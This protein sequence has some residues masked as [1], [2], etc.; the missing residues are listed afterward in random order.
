[1]SMSEAMDWND[2]FKRPVM[3]QSMKDTIARLERDN[4]VLRAEN[5]RLRE[6]LTSVLSAFSSDYTVHVLNEMFSD[7]H[8]GVL[9]AARAALE[10]K[11]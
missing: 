6:V 5:K 7:E 1:V 11:P 8:L 4:A 10:P 9:D 3:V 2:P